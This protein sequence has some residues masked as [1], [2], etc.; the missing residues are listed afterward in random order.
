MDCSHIKPIIISY[1]IPTENK[2]QKLI[3]LPSTHDQLPSN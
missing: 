1:E 3:L 2:M